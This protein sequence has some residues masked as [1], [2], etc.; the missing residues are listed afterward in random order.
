[1]CTERSVAVIQCYFCRTTCSLVGGKWSWLSQRFPHRHH[2]TWTSTV[3]PDH[4]IQSFVTWAVQSTPSYSCQAF[5]RR[6]GTPSAA[7]A[8]S[9][10][11]KWNVHVLYLLCTHRLTRI[12]ANQDI[13]QI[14]GFIGSNVDGGGFFEGRQPRKDS[15]TVKWS[16]R[17][18][19]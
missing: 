5:V 15:L 18:R 8:S 13:K 19:V 17:L 11:M 3:V 14:V 2:A 12:P 4:L 7:T 10:M 1:M 16:F 9:K 6:V